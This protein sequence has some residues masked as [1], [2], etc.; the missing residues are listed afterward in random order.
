[1]D[2]HNKS[3]VRLVQLKT[4]IHSSAFYI[5]AASIYMFTLITDQ[6]TVYNVK[7]VASINISIHVIF[8]V[9]NLKVAMCRL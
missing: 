5:K 8:T 2:Y 4:A 7:S 1:M 9:H 6:I 3:L